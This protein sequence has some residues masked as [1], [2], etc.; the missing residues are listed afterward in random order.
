[1]VVSQEFNSM[2]FD[3]KSETEILYGYCDRSGLMSGEFGNH[4]SPEWKE[5]MPDNDVLN[6]LKYTLDDMNFILVLGAWCGDSKEQVPRFVKL[7]DCLK[8]DVQRVLFIA[9]DRNKSAGGIAV[10]A[11][12]IERV[13]TIIVVKNDVEIGRITETPEETLEKDLLKIIRNA[14]GGN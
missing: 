1:M 12:N 10:G 13:P 7:L 6:N 8:Y 11:Y 9:V 14:N 5:Y 3:E 4:Y 2:I